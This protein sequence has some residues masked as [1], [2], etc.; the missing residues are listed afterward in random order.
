MKAVIVFLIGALSFGA[1]AGPQTDDCG[2]SFKQV[3]DIVR[4]KFPQ[5]DANY[6]HRFV[7]V[8]SAGMVSFEV[9]RH[10]S[11][12]LGSGQW[13]ICPQPDKSFYFYKKENPLE[14]GFF[15]LNRG[16]LKVYEAKG[17]VKLAIANGAYEKADATVLAKG[18]KKSRY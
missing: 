5:M 17:S 14:S 3:T 12:G 7:G 10:A 13:M 8:W 18:K 11:F 6:T 1:F 2:S 9:E 16:Q 4:S 15:R